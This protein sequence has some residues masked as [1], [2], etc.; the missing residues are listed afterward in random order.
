MNEEK[1]KKVTLYSYEKVWKVEKKIYA[2]GNIVLPVPIRPYDLLYFILFLFTMIFLSNIFTIITNIPI[3]IRL[4][5]IPYFLARFVQKKKLDGK[6][7]IKY[8]FGYLKYIFLD[9]G[10][11]IEH[12]KKNPDKKEQKIKIDWV[13]SKV[14]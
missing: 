7:P 1:E 2:F 11:Y 3:M 12:F 13:C 5:L 9:K 14:K 8:F 10:T 4:G 6:N